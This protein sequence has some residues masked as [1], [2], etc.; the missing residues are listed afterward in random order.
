MHEGRSGGWSPDTTPPSNGSD[1]LVLD[2]RQT[3]THYEA[4][5]SNLAAVSHC[6]WRPDIEQAES[7]RSDMLYPCP[8]KVGLTVVALVALF[9]PSTGCGLAS[10]SGAASAGH[11]VHDFIPTVFYNE[12]SAA[13]QP[14]LRVASGDTIRTTTI[15]ASGVDER[16]VSRGKARNPQ[17]GPFYVIGA[18]PGDTVAI[19]LTRLRLNRDWAITTDTLSDV[20]MTADRAARMNV[21]RQLVRWHLDSSR[22][23]ATR[24]NGSANLSGYAV[25][26]QPMLGCIALAPLAPDVV[27]DTGEVGPWGG[28]LDLNEIVEGTTV[29]L[30]VS[31]P[32]GLVYIGDA[33]AAQGDGELNGNGLETSMDVELQVEVLHGWPALGPRVESPTHLMAMG[34]GSSLDDAVRKATTN[35]IDWLMTRYELTESEV[36]QVV[37]TSAEY[38]VGA[39][40]RMSAGIAIGLQKDRLRS[41]K[42]RAVAS[43][44]QKP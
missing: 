19:R 28:N 15:D 37:G 22:H 21:Q 27:P 29:F 5:S 3:S 34:L 6:A 39:V 38:K 20:V 24:E 2:F 9:S 31:V 32:G 11:R 42:Q 36:A 16:G 25:P 13:T 1:G 4:Q 8:V 30:P 12:F 44:A 35:I 10:P 41:L 17:T 23:V 33:H 43:A 7:A 40:A 14:A 18:A 26:I